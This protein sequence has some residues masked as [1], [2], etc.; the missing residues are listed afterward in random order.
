[1]TTVNL[2]PTNIETNDG[3]QPTGK[4]E[5]ALR[6]AARKRGLTM[7]ELASLM[8]VT[9]SYLSSIG[10]GGAP[11][12]KAMRRKAME[13]LGEVPEQGLVYRQGGVVQG[14]STFIRE[15]AREM[16]MTLNQLADRV[17]VTLSFLSTV[18]RGRQQMGPGLQ[19][20]VERELQAPFKVEK[21]QRPAIDTCALWDRMDAHGISQNEAARRAG[22]TASYLSQ[23]MRLQKPPSGRVLQRLHEVLF[24]PSPSE[25]VTPVELK[26]LAWKKGERNGVVIRGAG[27]PGGDSIRVGGRAPWGAEVEYA[28]TAGYDSHGRVSVNPV[29]DSRGCAAM[30]KSSEPEDAGQRRGGV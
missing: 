4:T 28:Y 13:V 19:A 24:A 16:G 27:G 15:R 11:W 1:M 26:V 21:A 12:S 18:S 14:G 23:I 10:T 9:P 7:K 30:L 22:I 3:V 2:E 5:T 6:T 20:R 8:E 17:G 29:V 25:L